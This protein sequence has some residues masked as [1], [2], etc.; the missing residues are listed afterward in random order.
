[1]VDGLVLVP[2][3]PDAG[4][5]WHGG[6]PLREQRRMAGG[7]G[8][9]WLSNR[10]VLEFD[11]PRWELDGIPGLRLSAD[12]RWAHADPGWGEALVPRLRAELG[13]GV[14]HRRDL[15]VVWRGARLPDMADAVASNPSPVPD[16]VEWIV[17]MPGGGVPGCGDAGG[18]GDSA[19]CVG[20]TFTSTPPRAEN[21]PF[22]ATRVTFV[23][24]EPGAAPAPEPGVARGSAPDCGMPGGVAD[25][26]LPCGDSGDSASC[27]GQTFTSTPAEAEN[28]S[29]G[30]TRVAF[31][32]SEPGVTPA[33][34]PGDLLAR[35]PALAPELAVPVGVWAY[36]ALRIAAEVPRVGLDLP[37][38]PQGQSAGELR[39]SRLLLE[40]DD[41]P[42][43]G[44]PITADGRVVGRL[45]SSA[46]HY[47]WGP[48][49]L[50][51]LPAALPEGVTLR[52]GSATVT[53]WA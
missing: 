39:L 34:E 1:M 26:A 3:G 13:L 37:L 35:A 11:A 46:Q 19:S 30:A 47:E 48:I 27:V 43:V 51:L 6:A 5:V 12:G 45:G 10:D 14:W 8:V 31:V 41:L 42:L 52:A 49:A 38:T 2:D 9:L 50:G 24:S 36:E 15:A 4:L 44:A 53:V 40:A 17:P 21:G 32:P 18:S 25:S 20:Q 7:A 33:P 29:F 22:G 23:P 16:G 28:R